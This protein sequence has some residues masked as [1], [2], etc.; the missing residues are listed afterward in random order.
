MLKALFSTVALALLFA[1]VAHAV[2]QGVTVVTPCPFGDCKAAIGLSFVGEFSM[3]T[4]TLFDGV[5]FGGLSGLDYDPASNR[6]IA[7][8][9]DR[10]ERAPAR[11]YELSIEASAAGITDVKVVKTVTLKDKN[12]EAFAAKSVDPESIRLGKDGIYWSS[13]GDVKQLLPPFVRV[14]GPD[15]AFLRE[16]ELP[17]AF[18]PTADKSAGIRDNLAFEGLATLPGGDLMLEVESALFQDGPISGLSRGTLAR[19]IRYD[20]AS[21]RPKAEYV[22]PIAPIPQAPTVDKGYNDNGAS[23]IL[24]L[25]DHRLLVVERGF[26]Q[27][28]GSSIKV[29]MVDTEGATDV[30]AIPSLANTDAVIVPVRKAQVLDMRAMGLQPDN[31][32]AV[33]FARGTDGNDLLIFASDNNFSKEQ[34]TQFIAFKVLARP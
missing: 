6:Y 20:A 30:S 9:D 23:E 13:E 17:K 31:I 34:K 26:A 12:G 18:M 4:G 25:D 33:T 29:F 28:F 11:F 16:F 14:A 7:I 22:Y 15:G 10:S 2:E 32:E 5:E 1:P 21:G 8:S 27:G 3:P 19:M 24:S